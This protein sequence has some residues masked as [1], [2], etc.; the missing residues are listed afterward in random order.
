MVYPLLLSG[1]GS[2]G[3]L[4][5]DAAHV[6]DVIHYPLDVLFDRDHDVGQDRGAAWSGEDKHVGEARNRDAARLTAVSDKAAVR[7]TLLPSMT[8]SEGQRLRL[9]RVRGPSAMGRQ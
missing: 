8:A 4:R 1:M 3:E 2:F 6:V 5:A 9:D 7:V